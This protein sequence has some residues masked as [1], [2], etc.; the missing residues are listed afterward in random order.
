[1]KTAI[2]IPARYASTRFPGKPLALLTLPDG[3]RK[4]LIELSWAAAMRVQGVDE[5]HVLTDDDRIVDAA[6]AFGASVLMTSPDCRNGTERCAEVIARGLVTADIVVN[7]QGDAPLTPHW[8]VEDLIAA[9]TRDAS[10]QVVTPVLRCDQD[11]YRNFLEDRRAG[12]VGGTTAVFGTAGQA[13]Y[14]SKE[15]IPYIAPGKLPDPV[16]VFH[17]VGVYAYRADALNTYAKAPEGPLETLEGLEQ[18]RFLENGIPVKCV[19]VEGRGR[20]FWELNNPED[21]PR[22]EAVLEQEHA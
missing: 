8:F 9:M 13:L 19:E 12:R 14:F 18:L 22:I 7:L 16:P 3:T 5:C 2:L 6:R 15:V 17:H 4:S 1:M 10:A 21:I 20:S 11:A